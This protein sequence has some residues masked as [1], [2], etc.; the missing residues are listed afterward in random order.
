MFN[1]RVSSNFCTTLYIVNTV[2]CSG[3]R[4][5]LDVV[6]YQEVKRWVTAEKLCLSGTQFLTNGQ[7][8]PVCLQ[9]P[10][11]SATKLQ[12][13]LEVT[14]CQCVLRNKTTAGFVVIPANTKTLHVQHK[15]CINCNLI[16]YSVHSNVCWCQ[17]EIKMKRTKQWCN[18]CREETILRPRRRWNNNNN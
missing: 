9:T 17:L 5:C 7:C 13:M 15:Y 4:Q 18:S 1:R 11:P 10:R 2:Y 14:S 8:Q 12:R 16:P 3:Q 6:S